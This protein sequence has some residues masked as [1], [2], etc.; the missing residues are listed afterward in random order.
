MASLMS[1]IVIFLRKLSFLFYLRFRKTPL[2]IFLS[3]AEILLK[4]GNFRE[5]VLYLTFKNRL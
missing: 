2:K 1:P 5:N 4:N 3:L